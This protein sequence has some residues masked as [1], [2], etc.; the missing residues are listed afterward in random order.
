[1]RDLD[2]GDL[3]SHTFAIMARSTQQP[4]LKRNKTY[5]EALQIMWCYPV[6]ECEMCTSSTR[7]RIMY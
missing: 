4:E 1:M 5:Q 2:S 7:Y 6:M 3:N